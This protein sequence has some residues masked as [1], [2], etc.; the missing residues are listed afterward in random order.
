MKS[1]NRSFWRYLLRGFIVAIRRV[2]GFLM[3]RGCCICLWAIRAVQ[4]KRKDIFRSMNERDGSWPMTRQL[5]PIRIMFVVKY[6]ELNRKKMVLIQY[7][8]GIYFRKEC[9]KPGRKFMSWVPVI[10]TGFQWIVKMVCFIGE[11]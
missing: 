11:M 6:G 10:P 8:K 3:R 4:R 9:Q 7:R 2:I 5:P 1:Q